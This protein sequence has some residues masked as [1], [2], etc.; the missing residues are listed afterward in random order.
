MSLPGRIYVNLVA[1]VVLFA[2][3]V[4]W[5]SNSVLNPGGFDSTYPVAV[6]F[7]DATGLRSGVEVTFR[8]VRVGEVDGVTV[9]PGFA[10]ADLRI[11]ADQTLPIDSTFAVRRR[12]AV[13]EPYV[14]IEPPAGWDGT[15]PLI[16]TSGAVHRTAASRSPLAYGQLFDAADALLAEV[17]DDD[18][19]TV[20]DELASALGGRGDELRRI[21]RGTS[22]VSATLADDID[23]LDTLTDELTG[24][25]SILADEAPTIGASL[26]DLD[27]LVGAIADSRADIELLLD[28]VPPLAERVLALLTASEASLR[29]GQHSSAV[30][31]EALGDPKAIAEISRLLR[32]AET[33][34][35]VIPQAVLE[36]PDGRY[37]SGTFGFAPGELVEYDEFAA[38]E[39]PPSLVG[40][41]NVSTSEPDG[42][43]G[44][45]LDS[46]EGIA[47]AEG[48]PLPPETATAPVEDASTAL[49][50]D[51][52]QEPGLPLAV[53][54]AGTL[55][56]LAI[57][58]V[59]GSRVVPMLWG[60][61]REE[62]HDDRTR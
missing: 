19:G 32:A 57:T 5:A 59:V 23:V 41:A 43:D 31:G 46:V 18:L 54:L 39:Q 21:I 55:G 50:L 45:T 16:P 6:E 10:L 40:C 48:A 53:L 7:E 27:L 29:C 38:F 62:D 25:T 35:S 44:S 22:D 51:A 60:R 24:L 2:V 1:F 3:L 36:F 58:L 28:D 30:I 47:G 49:D 12:S 52:P 33:A 15:G 13:G 14:A 34:A 9:E 8:G 37:L 4:L 17:D 26:D 20:F 56:A 11:T 42:L 61:R